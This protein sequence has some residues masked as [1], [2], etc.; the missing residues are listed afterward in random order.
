MAAW[1]YEIVYCSCC[2]LFQHPKRNFESPRRHEQPSFLFFS[3]DVKQRPCIT[4][5]FIFTLD[6]CGFQFIDCTTV[7]IF[8][9]STTSQQSN[10]RSGTRLKTESETGERRKTLTPRF[11]DFFTDFEKNTRLFCSLFISLLIY[12]LNYSKKNR[13]LWESSTGHKKD[14]FF[15]VG[16]AC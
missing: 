6:T 15:P 8:A 14:T 5:C 9:Y 12:P 1:R 10:K 11:T 7:R 3:I 2:K 13:A 4:I 16:A